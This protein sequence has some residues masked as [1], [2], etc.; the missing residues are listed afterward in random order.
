VLAIAVA[1]SLSSYKIV[2]TSRG[3]LYSASV[4]EPAT[5]GHKRFFQ[6]RGPPAIRITKPPVVGGVEERSWP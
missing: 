5:V 3:I 4:D 2:A 6:A 1:P